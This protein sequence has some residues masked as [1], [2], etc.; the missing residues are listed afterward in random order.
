MN[1]PR[2]LLYFIVV[3]IITLFSSEEVYSIEYSISQ[4]YPAKY[5]DNFDHFEY[6]N[7]RAKK[8][9]TIRLS[10]FGT[11]ES[12]NPFLLKSL[13]PAGMNNLIFETLMVRSLDEPSSSYGHIASGY[14]LAKDGL[15]V[16]YFI[17]DNARFSNGDKIK[18]SDVEFSY[19]TLISNVSHPQYRLYWSDI[20]T[21]RVLDDKS[22]QF[23]FKKANPELHMIIGDLPVFSKKWLNGKSFEDTILD[24]PIAS[25]PYTVDSFEPGK[26][27]KYKKNANYW[28]LIEPTTRGMYNFDYIIYKYYKD[29]T[30]GLEA[31]KAGEYDYIFENHSKRWARDYS[32]PN[33]TNGIIFK[34]SLKHENNAGIQGFIF[35]TRKEI[36][37]NKQVRKA[38]TLAFDFDWS[39]KNLF[40][41]Q[42]QRCTSY[43]SNSE[44][45]ASK[46]PSIDEINM[47]KSLNISLSKIIDKDLTF[48]TKSK[49]IRNNLIKAKKIFDD[50]GWKVRDNILYD[51]NNRP[52]EFDFLLAQKGF[53][54]ILAPFA[55]NL[56]KL[57][58]QLNYRTI[59]V[60]LYQRRVDT[61]D[62]DMMVMS[63]SQSQSPGNELF[64]MFHSSSAERPGSYNVGGIINKDI[65]KLVDKIVYSTTRQE[66]I[67][68]S[69]LL[70]RIL[71]NE[72]Y[73]LP[74]W[75]INEHR[76][77]YFDKF[78]MPNKLPK[79]YQPTDY[80]LKTWYLKQ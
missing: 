77:A 22:I 49:N 24:H 67:T 71:W 54:R 74:N 58:I 26:F 10:A 35:N 59:D 43:F 18:A 79:Y 13:A 60:S 6:V 68:A 56:K 30:V 52:I 17:K 12:L 50:L 57:G 48:I 46:S 32:G 45:S 1:N 31:F 47:A 64:A 39:N 37:Q 16:T 9:G 80:V 75:Y 8:G 20:K 25:G 69:H 72:F 65:D 42:Y 15:S 2:H 73:L 40:Y 61:F 14:D 34:T 78:G 11:Y 29:M 62:F 63:Y 7:P 55:K 41:N 44:L 53:E 21:T 4:G 27:I 38:I 23:I 19:K 36:F 5:S 28:A 3:F 51:T 33:F 66:M 70:D 76:V